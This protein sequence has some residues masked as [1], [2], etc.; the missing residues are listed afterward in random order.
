MPQP[1]ETADTY[2]IKSQP[3]LAIEL[4]AVNVRLGA[5]VPW[6]MKAGP[7]AA[8]WPPQYADA[9][10]SP[11]QVEPVIVSPAGGGCQ[12]WGAVQVCA[13]AAPDASEKNATQSD[14]RTMHPS[15]GATMRGIRR[16]AEYTKRHNGAT[17][18]IAVSRTRLRAGHP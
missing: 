17:R 3:G 7:G 14:G 2:I 15:G 12:V 11:P 6:T 5:K 10:V 9:V 8:N 1:A 18:R 13:F 16:Q 4:M